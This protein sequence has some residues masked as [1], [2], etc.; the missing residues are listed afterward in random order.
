MIIGQSIFQLVVTLILFFAGEG[1]LGYETD[2]EI[3]RWHSTIFNTFVFMQI[4]NQYNS[5]RLDN[6]FNIFEGIHRNWWFIG[7]QFI[8]VGGQCLIMFVGG[9][10]F[11]VTRITGPQWGISLVLGVLSIP[12]AIIIRLI[13]DELF[14]KFIPRL[15]RRKKP[16]LNVIIEDDEDQTQQWNPALEEIREELTF[17]KKIRG[18]RMR[19]LAYKL[20][21]PRET[22]L[23]RSRGSSRSRDESQ[24]DLPQTPNNE[25]AESNASLSAP[26]T[27]EKTPR[28]RARSNSTSIFGPAA[29][30][31][32]IVAGSVAGGWSPLERRA[33]QAETVQFSRSRSASGVEGTAGMEVHPD[34]KQDDPVFASN[35]QQTKVPPSQR[36][37]LAPFFEHAPPHSPDARRSHSR[38]SSQHV[39]EA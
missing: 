23:P 8:I 12:I 20:Q 10:A 4:F 27:P 32:G 9:E 25:V 7:I 6:G 38:N 19:E 30:M 37:E 2:D 11:S 13:P 39:P 17:L 22:F 18:G 31:A 16:S 1:I 3:D 14:G 35:F 24:V 21:H 15:P 5:R 26:Q 34:T 29:A 33:E 36:P 28:K